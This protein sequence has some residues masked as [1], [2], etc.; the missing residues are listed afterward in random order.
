MNKAQEHSNFLNIL[1]KSRSKVYFEGKAQSL[2]SNNDKGIFDVLP[3]HANFISIIK[4][5][6]VIDKG[7][8]TEKKFEIKNGVISVLSNKIDVY[9]EVLGL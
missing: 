1:I 8:P 9:L 5:Y 6:I 3:H 4:D 7:L 2:T